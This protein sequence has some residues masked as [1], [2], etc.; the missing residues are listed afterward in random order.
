V[1][2]RKDIMDTTE[3]QSSRYEIKETHQELFEQYWKYAS[4]LKQWYIAF[5]V[6]LLVLLASHPE[7]FGKLLPIDKE[8][9][10]VIFFLAIFFQV[11]TV[12]LNK[13]SQ[14]YLYLRKI[15]YLKTDNRRLKLSYRYSEWIWIECVFD[16]LT[17]VL[18]ISGVIILLFT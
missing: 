2:S 12:F 9:V 16:V 10:F 5:G 11:I 14:Y 8:S 6:G 4:S 1:F 7:L 15:G 17:G 18:Y 3:P 13:I